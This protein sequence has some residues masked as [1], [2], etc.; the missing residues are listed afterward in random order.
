MSAPDREASLHRLLKLNNRLMAP[1]SMHLEHRHKISINE[2]RLLMTIGRLGSS[3]SHEL[4]ALTG[5]NAMSVSRAVTALEKH[6][7]I[8]LQV[9]RSNRRRKTITLTSE[10]QRLYEAMLPTTERVV[11]YL[12]AALTPEQIAA[13][14]ATVTTLTEALEAQDAKGRSLFL[15]STRPEHG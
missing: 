13:F 1:F 5:V 10:G 12:F 2:F 8:Q 6:G 9:D 15:E 14:D 7:R 3:A 11:E 4:A